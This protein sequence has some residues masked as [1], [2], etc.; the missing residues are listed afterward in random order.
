MAAECAVMLAVTYPGA[1]HRRE[2]T[3]PAGLQER[4]LQGVGGANLHALAATDAALK[5]IFLYQ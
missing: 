3:L 4:R 2:Y 5:E 1:E